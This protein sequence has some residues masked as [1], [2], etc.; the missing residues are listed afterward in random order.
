MKE[1]FQI[2]DRINV[3]PGKPNH[4]ILVPKAE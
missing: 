1:F 2:V 3:F 4:K